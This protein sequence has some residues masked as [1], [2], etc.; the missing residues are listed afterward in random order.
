MPGMNP[1]KY[2]DLRALVGLGAA[3]LLVACTGTPEPV[4]TDEDGLVDQF[5]VAIGTDPED[6]DT[7]GDG[8]SD[9]E[10]YLNYFDP[11]EDTDFPREGQYPRH[12]RPDDLD[13]D[14]TE[15]GDVLLDFTRVDQ[16]N[17]DI[18]LHEFYGNVVVIG[19]GAEW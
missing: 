3:T 5:E 8:F 10:E 4:D 1:I 13:G 6:A 7:D 2:L 18:S 9:G 15:I 12:A 16:Y 19:I 14:G 17:E 11:D